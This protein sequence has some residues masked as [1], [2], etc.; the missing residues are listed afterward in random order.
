MNS[1]S[2]KLLALAFGL[3]AFNL[4]FFSF[5]S[6]DTGLVLFGFGTMWYFLV[7]CALQV[8]LFLLFQ[9]HKTFLNSR[10]T[11]FITWSAALAIITAF[12]AM[13]RASEVDQLI[14]GAISVNFSIT[15][16]YIYSLTHD[17]FGALTELLIMPLQ[18][19]FSWMNGGMQATELLSET[20]KGL[21]KIS[22]N[23][24]PRFE[25]DKTIGRSI[26]RGLLLTVPVLVVLL[27]L[28][29]SADPIFSHTL[30]S[31]FN[32]S[33]PQFPTWIFS[34]LFF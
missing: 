9:P 28:L 29:S 23:S 26:F 2:R 18:V 20:S 17:E 24:I 8:F 15:A 34:R 19:F 4:L 16:F 11:T 25:I 22:K 14:L 27:I 5:Q 12:L 13:F 32:I 7:V 6:Q 10:K 1:M 21:S 31:I 3:L 30:G 33:L